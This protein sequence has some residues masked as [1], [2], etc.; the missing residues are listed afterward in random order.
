MRV[1]KPSRIR[2]FAKAYPDAA[3]SLIA[4]LR[5][6]RAARWLNI[7]EARQELPSADAARVASGR[8]VTIFNIGGNKYRLIVSIHYK[9]SMVY[10]LRFMT[11]SEY[12]RNKW[13]ESL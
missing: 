2:E 3:S 6:T 7:Q 10:V 8:T 11:H 1:V 5:I 9:W 13:K 12:D 4:W